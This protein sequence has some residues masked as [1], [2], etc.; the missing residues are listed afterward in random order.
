VQ[1]FRGSRFYA[2]IPA[3]VKARGKTTV[4]VESDL[5]VAHI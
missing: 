5:R 1:P 3:Q 4:E 2:R